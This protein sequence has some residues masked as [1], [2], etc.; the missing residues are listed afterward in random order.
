MRPVAAALA[1]LGRVLRARSYARAGFAT[2][3]NFT[4]ARFRADALYSLVAGPE[5]LVDGLRK[6]MVLEE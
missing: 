2:N 1:R 3:S 6:A 5:H 4:A